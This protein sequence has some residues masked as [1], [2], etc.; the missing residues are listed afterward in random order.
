LIV[1]ARMEDLVGSKTN[2]KA[3]TKSF[4][5]AML[6]GVSATA[7]M[8]Y[9]DSFPGAVTAGLSVVGAVVCAFQGGR[10]WWNDIKRRD[11]LIR[12]ATEG[13]GAHKGR[14]ATEADLE[15]A[16]MFLPLGRTLGVMPSSGR[17]IFEPVKPKPSSSAGPAVRN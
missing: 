11:D 15:E 2:E 16:G 1:M 3:I 4:V 12:F 14:W 17:V 10:A 6:C 5:G 13:T 9:I 7:L 8:P